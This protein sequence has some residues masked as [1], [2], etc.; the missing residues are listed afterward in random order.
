MPEGD[1][2]HRIARRINLALAGREIDLAEAPSPRSPLHRRA[3]ELRGRKLERAEAH[4]KHLLVEFSGGSVLHSH[5][6]MNGRWRV[7]V[8]G[9]PIA[10][11]S[12]IAVGSGGRAATQT[13][14]KLLRLVSRSRA[15][16]DP[17]LAQLGPDPLRAGFDPQRAGERLRRMAAGRDVG[18]ALL[19]QA[20]VAG[21]GNAIKSEAF[22]CA[23]IDPTRSV[24]SLGAEEATRLL[25]ETQRIMRISVESGRRPH[26]VYRG[27]RKR[28]PRCGERIAVRMQGD[29]SRAT[30]WCPRCQA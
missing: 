24:D 8:E 13:G 14:G 1:T 28:C 22:F 17:A 10:R 3:G 20:V 16:N 9:E 19:D 18:E 23:R 25:V 7:S 26:W 15:R 27:E 21:V 29:A 6:G 4:G 12:W 30:Y 5:L 11:G 2:I